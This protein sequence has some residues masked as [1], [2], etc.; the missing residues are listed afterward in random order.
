MPNATVL[1]TTTGL[2]VLSNVFMT[3]ALF[4]DLLQEIITLSVFVPFSILYMRQPLKLD[5]R[6]AGLCG[7]FH[8]P[9]RTALGMT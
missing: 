7:L 8:V 6:W 2:L 4:E 9:Q 3:F 1:L 5:F